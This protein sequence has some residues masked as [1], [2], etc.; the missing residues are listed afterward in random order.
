MRLKLYDAAVLFHP[1]E[2]DTQLVNAIIGFLAK[3][4]D[5]ARQQVINMTTTSGEGELEITLR[6]Y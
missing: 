1:V 5:D 2:G 6:G 3:D 4:E